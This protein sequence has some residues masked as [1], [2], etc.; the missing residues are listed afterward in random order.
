M[1]KITAVV[2]ATLILASTQAFAQTNVSPLVPSLRLTIDEAVN[3][4]LEHNLGIK[5]QRVDPQIRD[6]GIAQARSL[7]APQLTSSLSST[8]QTQAATSFLSG[9]ASSIGSGQVTTGLG[10]SQQ[11]PWGGS[12]SATW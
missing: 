9:G 11:L 10:L 6:V 1:S 3:L 8:N 7:W 2:L 12:Y 5:F 4:A